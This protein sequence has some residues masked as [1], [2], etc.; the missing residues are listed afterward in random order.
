VIALTSGIF[1]ISAGAL[2]V[3]GILSRILKSKK[4]DYNILRTLGYPLNSVKTISFFEILTVNILSFITL[5]A[6][7]YAIYGLF[8]AFKQ[9]RI[10]NFIY[11]F[12]PTGLANYIAFNMFFTAFIL[13]AIMTVLIILRYNK[14]L[15]R[16]SIKK[17]A[18][19]D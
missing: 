4:K 1:I 5:T 13:M 9:Y 7:F 18:A 14:K 17:S 10:L 15:F 11:I 3:S 12:F 16:N 2:F 8:F 19:A 6:L